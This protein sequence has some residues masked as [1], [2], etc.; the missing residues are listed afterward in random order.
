MADPYF[1][2]AYPPPALLTPV[3]PT[4]ISVAG[5]TV[6]VGAIIFI[7]LILLVWLLLEVFFF[8]LPSRQLTIEFTAAAEDAR[9]IICK[10]ALENC[11]FL[12]FCPPL[13]VPCN[14]SM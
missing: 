12:S 14:S 9:E 2:S 13:P 1:S 8:Y 7:A 11:K 6:F 4:S 5:W 3:L 10:A